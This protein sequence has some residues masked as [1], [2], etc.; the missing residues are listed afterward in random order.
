LLRSQLRKE[1]MMGSALQQQQESKNKC[2]GR[3]PTAGKKERY[4]FCLKQEV[5][6]ILR[7]SVLGKGIH[8][9]LGE[10]KER[11]NQCEV[12]GKE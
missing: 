11:K 12:R 1:N 6:R 7:K 4:T 10:R 5:Q 8:S 2:E 9:V 3:S